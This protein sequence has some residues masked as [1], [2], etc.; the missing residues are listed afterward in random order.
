MLPARNKDGGGAGYL[1]QTMSGH[2][3]TAP[4]QHAKHAACKKEGRWQCRVLKT[5]D[6]RPLSDSP[7]AAR[8]ACCLQ[9]RRTVAVLGT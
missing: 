3:Q 8:Q 9:E 4:L 5:N 6:E 7:V 1:K 2:Y